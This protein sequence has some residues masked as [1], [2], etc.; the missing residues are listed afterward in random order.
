MKALGFPVK[1]KEVLRALHDHGVAGAQA[2]T[3]DARDFAAI[4]KEAFFGRDPQ[5]TVQRAFEVLDSDGTGAISLRALRAAARAA[6]EPLADEDLADMID[7]FDA[8]GDGVIDRDEFAR[9]MREPD[10][11]DVDD[12]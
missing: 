1:K 10:P 7:M 5:E 2:A 3:I 9:I 4:L 6:G 8:N 11:F 12:W